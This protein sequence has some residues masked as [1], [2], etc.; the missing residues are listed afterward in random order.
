M[1]AMGIL[2]DFLFYSVSTKQI[3]VRGWAT[4]KVRTRIQAL[5]RFKRARLNYLK[6]Y[7]KI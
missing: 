6:R 1:K 5:Y 7:W 2:Q 4:L 3:K